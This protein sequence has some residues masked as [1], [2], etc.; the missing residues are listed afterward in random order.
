V[1]YLT[2]NGTRES[3]SFTKEGNTIRIAMEARTLLPVVL[4]LK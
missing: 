2:Q 1:E 4:F 3:V